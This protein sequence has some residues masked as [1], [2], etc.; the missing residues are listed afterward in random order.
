MCAQLFLIGWCVK[1]GR[2]C[3]CIVTDCYV[4][5]ERDCYVVIGRDCYVVTG[6]DC[7]VVTGLLCCDETRLQ[8]NQKI[9][10]TNCHRANCGNVEGRIVVA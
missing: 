5:T 9:D 4:V 3:C 10:A 7:C 6:Q 1:L 8:R 2:I